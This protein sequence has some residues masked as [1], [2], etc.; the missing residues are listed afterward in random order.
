MDHHNFA[1]IKKN[2]AK[3][4][5]KIFEAAGELY[6]DYWND[7]F[8]F[9]IFENDEQSFEEAFAHTHQKYLLDAGIAQAENVLELA[10]GRGGFTQIIADHTKGSVLG[11]DI[12]PAQLRQARKRQRENLSF[13]EFDIMRIN[14]LGDTFDTVVFLD[15]ACY[16]PD[17]AL[18]IK[19]IKSVMKPGAKLLMVDWCKQ[20]GLN[21]VQEELILHPFMKYW[22]IPNLETADSYESYFRQQGFNILEITDMN[23]KT[24]KNWDFSYE[25]GLKGLKELSVKDLPGMVWNS[26]KAG[27]DGIRIMKE[28]FPAML[29]IKA[30]FDIGFLRYVY[31][32]VE[33]T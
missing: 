9:A 2:Y 6:A 13:K 20:P 27:P 33:N 29:Y 4:I 17:K 3:V 1:Y 22:A 7:L 14:E 16:L 5:P 18:A 8:H 10:C 26:I 11:I 28:Q 12:S 25:N 32:L 30:G 23:D 15:A 31:F 19:K 24:R 21:F